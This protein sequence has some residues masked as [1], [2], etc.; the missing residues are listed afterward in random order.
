MRMTP[1]AWRT[2]DQKQK[3]HLCAIL[4]VESVFGGYMTHLVTQ[5]V[6]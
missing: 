5:I 2:S 1:Q 4:H 3:N 6:F